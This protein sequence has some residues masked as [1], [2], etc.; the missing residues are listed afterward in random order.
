MFGEGLYD[1][2]FSYQEGLDYCAEGE[3]LE[4][5]GGGGH[6][7]LVGLVSEGRSGGIWNGRWELDVCRCFGDERRENVYVNRFGRNVYLK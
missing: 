7:S 4:G 6:F 1:V 3:E 5:C 2:C